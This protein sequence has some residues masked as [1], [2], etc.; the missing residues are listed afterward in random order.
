MPAMGL[1]LCARLAWAAPAPAA[2]P[3]AESTPPQDP[4]PYVPTRH[5]TVRDLLWLADAGAHDVV[6]DLGS[7]DGRMVIAA[8]RD[9]GVRRAV[10]IEI[11]PELIQES[12]R[13]AA[14][15]KV[16][17]R[18]QFV[19][20]D[21]FTN[22]LSEASVVVLYLGHGP[23]LGLRSR[24]LRQLKPDARIVSHQFGMGEWTP[25]KTL[26]V[27]A[28]LLGM[29]SE[30][31]NGFAN[32]PDVP[33]CGTP[34]LRMNHDVLSEWIVPAPVAGVWHGK[35]RTG[36]GESELTLTLHQ[37]HVSHLSGSFLWSGQTNAAGSLQADL[38]GS[39]LRLHGIPTNAPYGSSV[40]M[41]FDGHATNDV[42]RGKLW[43]SR[44][45]GTTEADWTARR[46]GTDLTGL[47]EW[48][49]PK[50]LPV[51]LKIQRRDGQLTATYIDKNRDVPMYATKE[52]DGLPVS[53]FY[54]FGGG[55]YFTLLLGRDRSGARRLGPEDGWVI[56]EAIGADSSLAGAIA[57]Y[58][59][60]QDS[61][62]AGFAR[63][64]AGSAPPPPEKPALKTGKRPWQPKRV[65]S[66][67]Q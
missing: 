45:P 4:I 7:G 27:R 15:A 54:D 24:L 62:T 50:D 48:P 19:H 40:L 14:R 16:A 8:A 35:V 57:F 25:D 67:G 23:N 55:F 47:W 22:D 41:W 1:L 64:A 34:F 9:F 31:Y 37:D 51:Q 58:P 65:A 29:Y 5:D 20:G 61:F 13:N 26:D 3:A 56:G 38:W 2:A 52:L 43:I 18:V 32:N 44:R 12:R 46:D 33:D 28:A 66:S 36:D 30:P 11:K 17:N 60:V 63:A 6:Y 49:G 53:D 39:H 10:G 21:L 42:L 59:Y